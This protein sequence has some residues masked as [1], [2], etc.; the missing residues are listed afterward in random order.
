MTGDRYDVH[1]IG[2]GAAV[3]RKAR[4]YHSTAVERTAGQ[5]EIERRLRELSRL[6]EQHEEALEDLPDARQAVDRAIDE[7]KAVASVG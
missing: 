4:G 7:S 5:A 1:N 6:L 3:G 2:P